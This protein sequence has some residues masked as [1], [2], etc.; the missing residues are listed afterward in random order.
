LTTTRIGAI[1][2]DECPVGWLQQAGGAE[3]VQQRH[4]PDRGEET[5]GVI[6]TADSRPSLAS[7]IGAI[8]RPVSLSA[9]GLAA[10]VALAQSE[11]PA[12][13]EAVLEE[14]IITAERRE[15]GLQ[16]T[17][18][19]VA[20]M[21]EAEL[22][23]LGA[24]EILDIP[25]HVPNIRINQTAGSQSNVG[26]SI[27]GISAT[28]PALAIDPAV[29]LY[30]DGVYIGRHAGAAFDIVDLE[31]I[32][33]LRGP[34]GTLYGRNSTGGAINL[35]TRRPGGER[36][37][38][39]ALSYGSHEYFRSTTSVNLPL[40]EQFAAS[41]SYNHTQ[42]SGDLVSLYS[43]QDLGAFRSDA[44][45]LAL[46][47][48]PGEHFTAD[49]V[50]DWSERTANESTSQMVHVRPGH[51]FL[52]G[53]FFAQLAAVAS[54]QRLSALAMLNDDDSSHTS[55]LYGHALTLE[56]RPG[57]LTVRSITSFRHW[58]EHERASDFGDVY[59]E[60]N[61]VLNGPTGTYIPAGQRVT[62][63]FNERIGEQD[64]WS[65]ELQLLGSAF[66]D[67]LTYTLG[68]Y[69][70]TEEARESNDQSL[71][72]PALFA[73]GQLPAGTQAFLCA[74]FVS[75]APCFGKSVRLTNPGWYSTDNEAFAVY[76]Q[77]TW[78]ISDALDFTLGGRWSEDR[79]STTFSNRF[80]DIGQATITDSHSWSDFSPSGTLSWK[81]ADGVNTY[82]K[83]A[84]AYRSGGYNA[85]A[86][87]AT[88]FT[89]PVSSETVLAYELGLKSEFWN[90]RARLNV[91]L[92][93]MEYDDRQV[94]QF[95]A[96]TGGASQ[97]IVNAGKSSSSG[98]ELDFTVLPVERL[99][100]QLSYG[101]LE[102]KWDEFISAG[103]D[104]VTGLGTGVTT[105]ISDIASTLVHAPKHTAAAS[106]EYT[107]PAMD[108]GTWTL[109]VD[110]TYASLRTFNPQLNLFDSIPAHHLIDA[111]LTLRDIP[112]SQGSLQLSLWGR[113][114]TDEEIREW[115]I[116]F[117]ALG[118]A[119]ATFREKRTIGLDLRYQF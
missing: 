29:G 2:Y 65:Q 81:V 110:A 48:T 31:R 16:D 27:R 112:V 66:G 40:S 77:A 83:V 109:R 69:Y 78:A 119:I 113:N 102:V 4:A 51:I 47:W 54:P 41:L 68:A 43:G 3:N 92:F 100:L 111:R 94:P 106:A 6:M 38:T 39:Q 46:R 1:L 7:I 107:F 24:F 62:N 57:D 59:A 11:A 91:A 12:S 71:V 104:P 82:F 61:T 118:F 84:T 36:R 72:L 115:G 14:V 52:G 30:V 93:D 34:Q 67:R 105:D 35:V 15:A 53:R 87:T 63:F 23:A 89:S 64:Q 9:I 28:D 45:R 37:F 97:R 8:L 50:F 60:A 18:I 88:S 108:Y 116:D 49:Y 32:E 114:L 17:P 56:W 76:G 55:D 42:R 26:I 117:G 22:E 99:M 21:G 98:L 73:F 103:T 13:R 33:V 10:P 44:A 101:Y 90:R 70:F 86:S 95:E 85:R 75:P 58:E 5:L 96:G 25:N 20:V 74:D 19:S 79:K 80:S